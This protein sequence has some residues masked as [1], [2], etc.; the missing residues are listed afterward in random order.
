LYVNIECSDKW[1]AQ[2]W[3]NSIKF[4]KDHPEDYTPAEQLPQNAN[5]NKDEKYVNLQVYNKITGKSC[6]KD[7][8]V[9]CEEFEQ[10]IML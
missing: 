1:Q 8:D 10:K 9:L 6:F 5:N 7:Y 4:V 2:K 3:I